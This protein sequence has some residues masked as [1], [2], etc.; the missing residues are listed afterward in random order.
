MEVEMVQHRLMG[1]FLAVLGAGM[2]VSACAEPVQD[3]DYTQPNA[4]KKSLFQGEWYFAR[5]VVDVPYESSGTFVGDRQEWLFG[6]DFP[7]YK[8]RWRMEEGRLMACRADDI[9]L[10]GNSDGKPQGPNG[11]EIDELDPQK[12]ETRAANDLDPTDPN[13]MKFP[14]THPVAAFRIQHLDRIRAYNPAT[15]EQSNV[16][17]ES[18]SERP[19][20]EREYIRINWTDQSVANIDYNLFAQA[21]YGWVGRITTSYY[22]QEENSDCRKEIVPGRYDY[23]DCSEGFLPP[24]YEDSDLNGEIDSINITNR[25]ALGTQD[26]L[27]GCFLGSRYPGYGEPHCTNS[28]IGMRYSFMRVPDRTPEEQYE[29]VYYPDEKFERVGVWR[30]KKATYEPGRG[31]TDFKKYLATRFQLWEKTFDCSSGDCTKLPLEQRAIKPIDYYLNRSFPRDLKPS[32]F[33]IAKQWNDSFSGVP[34]RGN[35]DFINSCSVKCT[36]RTSGAT[37]DMASCSGTDLNWRMEG[38]C[39]FRLHENGGDKFLGDLRYN[40]IAF[41]EDPGQ[42]QPCGIGGPANDPETGELINAVAYVYGA[43]CF[44]FLTTRLNDMM[45]L[46]C[47]QAM[48]QGDEIPRSCYEELIGV[49]DDKDG[50]IDE[51]GDRAF[52]GINENQYL[53]GLKVL[54][55][56]QAQGLTQGPTTPIRAIGGVAREMGNDEA[57]ERLEKVREN[58]EELRHHQSS[59]FVRERRARELGLGRGLITDDIAHAVSG[60]HAHSAADLTEE[61]VA[62]VD[63][64]NFHG[65]SEAKLRQRIDHLSSRAVEPAEFLFSDNGLWFFINANKNLSRAELVQRLRENSFKAVTLHEIGHN[66]GLRHN[67]I[68]SFDRANYF[69]EYWDIIE[70]SDAEYE[71]RYNEP[72]PAFNPYR[73]EDEEDEAQFAARYAEWDKDRT[74][75]R[76]IQEDLGINQ[77]RYTSIMDYHGTYYADWMGLGSYDKAAMRFLYA[78]LVDRTTCTGADPEDCLT[79]NAD[80]TRALHDRTW[81]KWYPGGELCTSNDQCPDSANG[82]TCRPNPDLGVSVCSNWEDD[83]RISGRYNGRQAFCSD[84]RVPDQPFCNRF[85]EGESSEEIVRNMIDLYNRNFIF[86][87]FRRYRSRFNVWSY[88]GRLWRYFSTIGG[89][90]QS[91]L[92]KYFYE[93]GFRGNEGPGGFEDMMRATVVGF[94]FI[95]NVL[96]TPQSGAYEW[97]ERREMYDFLDRELVDPNIVT[98]D[99]VNIPLGQGKTLYSSYE[100]GYYGETDRLAYAGVYHDKI[101]AMRALVSRYWGADAGANDERFM[102][103]FYDFFPG[104]YKNILGT[105][106]AG[107]YK[108]MGLLYDAQSKTLKQRSF[109][110]GSFFD[111]EVEFDQATLNPVGRRVEPGASTLLHLYGVLYG[112]LYTPVYF[113]LSFMHDTR[114]FEVG[115]EYS[116]DL[117][118]IGA[119]NILDCVLPRSNRRFATVRT[120]TD[121]GIGTRAIQRCRDLASEFNTLTEAIAQHDVDLSFVLPD[122]MSREEADDRLRTLENELTSHEDMLTNVNHLITRLGLGSL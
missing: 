7:A 33:D 120:E 58:F 36:D 17:R 106:I 100:E 49:D 119:E 72:A 3:V 1:M 88:R 12:A 32:A 90:M 73:D 64:L 56:M 26:G 108:N 67:F 47:S 39:A 77:Y 10:G 25:M 16:I 60:G 5:T 51:E 8:V 122:G 71:R 111:E 37:K 55:I 57:V 74:N 24:R 63:P 4:I 92:Y 19:W 38:N 41:I 104:A 59:L 34:N 99:L 87:N 110:D 29:E 121:F 52:A 21:G 76:R 14:C 97:D 53:R 18:G 13:W 61:E 22:V 44:D 35:H 23:S 54:E 95:G 65:N 113:D 11:D 112:L 28:E 96:A 107:D 45:D 30:V 101:M 50:Q 98:E 86:N 117:D 42:A 2:L 62:M 114:I 79:A 116:F 81:V 15:G 68:S 118:H 78:G 103:N 43:G 48:T 66:M 109:W 91:L 27:F 93:P 80:G 115:G 20:Y 46:L 31:E 9:V 6:D 102:L 84:D 83:E 75:L 105:F 94:D 40:Y 82:Q 70:E 89:Q 69:P 85:D